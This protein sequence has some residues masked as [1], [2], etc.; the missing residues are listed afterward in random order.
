MMGE[1]A[2][3]MLEGLLDEETGEYIGDH[4]KAKYGVEAPGFPVSLNREA[5]EKAEQK[6]MNIERNARQ[7]KTKCPV[8]GKKVKEVGLADHQRDVHGA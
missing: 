6:A 7:K 3:M 2:D 8:C 5:R 1:I 4:N